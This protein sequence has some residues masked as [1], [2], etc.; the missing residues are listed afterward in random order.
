MMNARGN[1]AIIIVL[2]LLVI[3]IVPGVLIT[4]IPQL[5]ILF[6]IY[7][8]FMIYSIIRGYLGPGIIT[9]VISA[10]LIWFLVFKYPG[11]FASLWVFQLS[12]GVQFMS[13]IIWGIGTSKR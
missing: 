6:Q 12:L 8:I 5:K 10:V 2:A 9:I 7:A 3:A 1:M 4:F 13:I 11:I